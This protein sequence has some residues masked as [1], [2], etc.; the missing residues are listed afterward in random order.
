MEWMKR[1]TTVVLVTLTLGLGLAWFGQS[2]SISKSEAQVSAQAR[3]L[4]S[5]SALFAR[6]D[7]AR[8]HGTKTVFVP[9]ISSIDELVVVDKGDVFEADRG[10]YN[11]QLTIRPALQRKAKEILQKHK[12]PWGSIVALDPHTGRILALASHSEREP[13]GESVAV[14]ATFP[15]ASL[16][17]MITAAA[18]VET[19]GLKS[20]E[21][22]KFR[23]GNYTLSKHN[24]IPNRK[25]DVRAM[26]LRDALGK[27]C[28]PVFG[29]IALNNLN[30]RV[31]TEYAE[32]FFFN[33]E[34]QSDLP[35]AA[36]TF[37][38]PSS[39]YELARTAAGFGDVFISP[40]HAAMITAALGNE[41]EMMKPYVVE[42]VFTKA[43]KLTYQAQSE[44]LARPVLRHTAHELM[45][46]MTA[47]VINGTGRR[48]F[49][50][51]RKNTAKGV[52][53]AAKTGTLSGTNPKG[54]YHWMVAAFPAEEPDIAL[55]TLVI[56]S[57]GARV[58]AGGLAQEF[59]QFFVAQEKQKI[60]QEL[61]RASRT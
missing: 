39:D 21:V 17:K 60:G 9:K 42:R 56:D 14:R 24:Y 1:K 20:S 36:S 2:L 16:F 44:V 5:R 26:T 10:Q 30:A 38:V 23:G 53:V 12:V 29:R 6:G 41:G 15:A 40:V 13:A 4:P 59:S 55:A 33:R 35:V 46:M 22:V 54:R 48:Y 51:L 52:S 37:T 18:A 25:L 27:S 49:R 3:T 11:Y 28:N 32:K 57:G 50:F 47:T 31:L 43:G 19:A 45:N 58:S 61:P 34:L 7:R 8:V